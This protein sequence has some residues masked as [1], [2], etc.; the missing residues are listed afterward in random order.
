MGGSPL[1]VNIIIPTRE[2]HETLF[3]TIRTCLLQQYEPLEIIISDNYSQDMTKDVVYSFRDNRI[4]YVNPGK[5]V[6][7]S[8]NWEFALSYVDKGFVTYIGDDDGLLP[9]SISNLMSLMKENG[10]SV[11]TW[12]KAE[13]CWPS[14]PDAPLQNF[15]QIPLS[16]NLWRCRTNKVMADCASF[17]VTYNRAPG[18]YNSL[19]DTKVIQNVKNKTGNFFK[20]IT[21]DVY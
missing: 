17:W 11:I 7:M 4:K 15:L 2:R 3:H 5:R 12:A 21:P 8:S 20:S 18:I 19:V 10:T 6:G 16:N 9:H 13:Y 14:F 1:K